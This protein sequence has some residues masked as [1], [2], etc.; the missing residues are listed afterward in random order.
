MRRRAWALLLP[1][2]LC[3][4]VRTRERR[5]MPPAVT[6]TELNPST[7][8]AGKPFFA[9]GRGRSTLGVRGGNL[10]PQCRVRIGPHVLPTEVRGNGTE[11]TAIVPDALHAVPGS[12]QVVI[13]QPDGR[14]SNPLVFTVVSTAGPAPVIGTVYPS[15][16]LAGRDFN[17]QPEGG[18]AIGIRGSN[19]LPGCAILFGSLEL[20]TVYRDVTFLTAFVPPSAYAAPGVIQVRVRNPDGKHSQPQPFR[21]SAR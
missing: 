3:G 21:V 9:D 14:Q 2:V 16:T 1:F 12:Y 8:T 20:E 15:G 6:I 10:T 17:V 19:F 4:C 11:A 18:S 5:E 13:D 7:V